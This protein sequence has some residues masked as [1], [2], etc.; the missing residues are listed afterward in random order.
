MTRAHLNPFLKEMKDIFYQVFTYKQN[1]FVISAGWVS[2]ST[3]ITVSSGLS[4][5]TIASSSRFVLNCPF[6]PVGVVGNF[7]VD[8]VLA[9]PSAALAEAGDPVDDPHVVLLAEQG[10]STVAGTRV[11]P[12]SPVAGTEHVLRDV[13]VL[14]HAHAVAHRNNGHLTSY[15]NNDGEERISLTFLPELREAPRFQRSATSSPC[16]I[17]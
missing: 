16:P 1:E 12:T 2:Q 5:T 3:K 7:C 11:D 10:T 13:V 17:Q 15:Q 14:V 8:P 9:L 4:K 6:N